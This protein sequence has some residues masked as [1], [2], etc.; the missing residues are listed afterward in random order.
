MSPRP[1]HPVY[2]PDGRWVYIPSKGNNSLTVVDTR[3][4]SVDGV[5]TGD[6]FAEPHGAAVSA[7]GRWIF[8]SNSD[9]MNEYPGDGGTV[10]VVDAEARRIA[11]VIPVGRNATGIVTRAR[12]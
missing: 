3:D 1:W 10:V 11:K 12:P 5:V 9:T 7:D 8:V 4:W 6:G 2:S